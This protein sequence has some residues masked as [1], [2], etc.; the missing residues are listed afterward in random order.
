MMITN[1]R[2]TIS[3]S[4]VIVYNCISFVLYLKDEQVETQKSRNE[5]V[6]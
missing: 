4:D 1:S 6:C 3:V 5:G 2:R